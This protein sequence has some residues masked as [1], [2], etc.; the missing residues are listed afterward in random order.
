MIAKRTLSLPILALLAFAAS[1]QIRDFVP[2]VRPVYHPETVAFLNKL[3][4]SMKK[5]GYDD[6]AAVLKGYA[7]GGFGSGFVITTDDG[8]NYVVTNRHVVSEAASITLEFQKTDGSQTVYKNCPV[9]AVDEDLDL[10]LV[11]FPEGAKPFKAGLSFSDASIEDGAEV[12]SAGYPG[13][14]DSPAW[15]LGKGNITNGNAKIPEL[16]DPAITALIQHSAQVDPG[17]SGGPLLV[18]DKTN[19][20]HY[21][22][23]GVNTWKAVNRQAANFSI[24]AAAIKK[25]IASSLAR[26]AEKTPQAARLETRCR[27]FIGAAAKKDAYRSIARLVS[28]GYVASDGEA[29][30]KDALATAPSAVRSEIVAVFSDSSP[31]EGIRLAIAYKIQTK[32]TGKDGPIPLGF[33]AVDGNADSVDAAVP[34][35]F[36]FQ[37]KEISLP[38]IREHGVWRLASY[39]FKDGEIA[40]VSDKK[41]KKE[42]GLSSLTFD[43]SPY[44]GL[45]RLGAVLSLSGE[46]LLYG[47]AIDIQT[48]AFTSIGMSGAFRKTT[49]TPT[50]EW[51][52]AKDGVLIEVGPEFI[53]QLPIRAESFAVIPHAGVKGGILIDTAT[54]GSSDGMGIYA[55]AKGG[56]SFGFGEE[57]KLLVGVDY[58]QYLLSPANTT[59]PGI[60]IWIGFG[61]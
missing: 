26:D 48:S 54:F 39:P 34:V 19:A 4:D 8:A 42:S 57:S 7:E 55:L 17:N 60:A 28:Y 20:S 14:G 3:S 9:L 37:G 10:A 32:L 46:D 38:W 50:S 23:I 18:P 58:R 25:F 29:I 45:F 61:M 12:W 40:K 47:A 51:D 1:A 35:R 21:Q 5:D 44:T 15:Q 27:D 31:I 11:S 36:S 30:L 2:V 53:L 56:L 43:E 22:V 41:D 13:L 16:A 33:V 6:A 59:N 24:P 52:T 49:Y